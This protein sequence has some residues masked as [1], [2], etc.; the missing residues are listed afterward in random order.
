VVVPHISEVTTL[1][2][3]KRESCIAVSVF[4]LINLVECHSGLEL[5]RCRVMTTEGRCAT[6]V[7]RAS[8][9]GVRGTKRVSLSIAVVAE[10]IIE[11]FVIFL[12]HVVH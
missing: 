6:L 4:I 2:T 9:G 5:A 7:E 12:L 3:N 10:P 1:E 11:R 8:F